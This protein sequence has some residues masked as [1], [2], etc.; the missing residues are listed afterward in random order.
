MKT[1]G[2]KIIENE[3]SYSESNR[4]D[5]FHRDSQ[6]SLEETKATDTL[7]TTRAKWG[8]KGGRNWENK[9]KGKEIGSP[10][11]NKVLCKHNI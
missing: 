10:K 8:M 5:S 4:E 3:T 2:N 11:R 6:E 7:M 1:I 9:S